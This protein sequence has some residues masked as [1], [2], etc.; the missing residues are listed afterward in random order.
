MQLDQAAHQRE[1]DAE[2]ALRPIERRG[3]LREHLEEAGE[4]PRFD[5]DAG[6]ANRDHDLAAHA[7]GA[8]PDVPAGLGVARRVVEQ[9]GKDLREPRAIGLEPD[10]LGR[11]RDGERVP[12]G[13]DGGPAGFDRGLQDGGDVH[14]S[15][16]QR[17]L[18][19]ADAAHVEQVVDE[20]H[21]QQHL[22]VDQVARPGQVGV[23]GVGH[24]HDLH[25]VTDRRQR[26]AQLV[27][28]RGEEFVLAPVALAQRLL[29]HDAVGDVDGHATDAAR[30]AVG[31]EDR[32]LAHQ[33]M[34]QDAVVVPQRLD[35]LIG[36]GLERLAVVGAELGRGRL[37]E[38]I[39]VLAAVDLRRGPAERLRGGFVHEHVASLEVLDPGEPGERLHELREE[40]LAFAQA[41]LDALVLLD[42]V[43]DRD[44]AVDA[45]RGI[46]SRNVDDLDPAPPLPRILD[47][48]LVADFLSGEHRLEAREQALEQ[49]VADHF[50]DGAADDL[51]AGA[52]DEGGIRAARP[53]VAQVAAAAGDARGHRVGDE[54]ELVVRGTAIQGFAIGH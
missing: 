50:A 35:R 24:A 9:V 13:V 41:F 49:L 6:V 3:D 54:Q 4:V 18:V 8:D 32:E 17:E 36:T 22:A 27:G 40:P 7:R 19:A 21:H 26:I 33:R 28:E 53:E 46:A 11:Q 39:L 25:G 31:A 45:A 15:N 38:E 44:P 20:P 48:V 34:V 16:A 43:D 2:A 42:V 23:R 29:G 1:A 12:R 52:P 5:A 10:R 14:G 47:L 37:G 51:L 30:L